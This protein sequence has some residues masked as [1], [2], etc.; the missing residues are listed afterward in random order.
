MHLW[1]ADMF[2]KTTLILTVLLLLKA[3]ALVAT[4]TPASSTSIQKM[5]AMP[6]AFTKNMGQWDERVLFRANAGGAIM[7]FTKEGVT[8]QFTRTISRSGDPM[9]RPGVGQNRFDFDFASLDSRLRGNDI[10]RDSVEQLVLTAKFLGANLNPEV[11]AEG[12]LEYK[13]NYFIGNDPTK[14]HTDV[15]NY[16][17][18]T[19]KDIYPGIDLRYSGDGG[20][21]AAYEFIAAPGA[22]IAQVKVE[23]EGAEGT[24]TD[25]EG[26]LTLTTKWG[27]MIAAMKSPTAGDLSGSVSCSQL[28]EKMIG[29]GAGGANRQALGILSF[30]LSYSTYLGGGGDDRG[31]GIAVDGF[32]CAYVTGYTESGDLP[33]LNAYDNTYG[34]GTDY[35]VAKL[36]A[37][38]NALVY[39]TYVGGSGWDWGRDIA[40]DGFGCAYVTGE[41]NSSDYPTQNAYD[42]SYNGGVVDVFVT[43]LSAAGSSLI[44]STYLGGSDNDSGHRLVVDGSGYVYVTGGTRS[45]GFPTQNPYQAYQGGWDVFVTKLSAAG[46]SLNYSTFLGGANA[47]DEQGDGIAVDGLGCAYVT[48]V[49]SDSKFPT[50]NAYDT[51]INGDEDAF[52][53]KFSAAGNAL[54]YSTY[55]GG[56]SGDGGNSIAVDGSGCAYM[57]GYTYSTNFPTQNPY[58]T[59][60]GS[61]DAFV[62][63]L[64][65]SGNI[66]V[67]STYLGGG[68]NEGGFKIAVDGSGNAFVTGVTWSSDFPTLNTYQTDQGDHDAF[69]TEFSSSGNSLIYST[70]LG[71]ANVDE[72]WDIA[73]DGSGNAYVTGLTYSSDFPI[74]NPCQST[75]QGG[76]DAFV[77][78]LGY[79]LCGNANGDDHV[80]IV[81]V[82]YLMAYIFNDSPAPDPLAAGNADGQCSVNIGD[83]VYLR[84]Y[85]FGEGPAPANCQPPSTCAFGTLA[86]NR[87]T[88]GCRPFPVDGDSVAIPIYVSNNIG[89]KGVSVGFHY[90]SDNIEVTSVDFAGSIAP[91]NWTRTALFKP[92]QNQVLVGAI[93]LGPSA[94]AILPQTGGLLCRLHARILAGDPSQPIDLDSSFVGPGGDFMIVVDTGNIRPEFVNCTADFVVVPTADTAD[95]FYVKQADIDNDNYSDVIYTGNTADSLY[96]AYGKADGTLETP[97]NYLKVTKAAL[98]VDFVNGDSL[99]DIVAHTTGKVYVL[100]NSGNRNFSIDSQNVSP[101]SWG[102]EADR[103]SAFPAIATGYFN[104][105]A[106]LDVVVSENKILYGNGNGSFPTSTTMSFSFDAV[107]V[108]DFDRNGTDDIAVTKGDSALIY[109]N[110]GNGNITRSAGV[111]IGY[112][113]HDF[114]S[115]GAG[116]D[117]NNDGKTDFVAVTG[118]TVGTNDTSV[119]TI[120]LGNG[121]GGVTS[122]DTLRI[123]GTALNLALADID[124]DHDLDISLVNATTRSLV[125]TANDG[126]GNFA[127]PVSTSLGSSSTEPLYA[128]INADLDRNGAPDFVIGGQ[129]GNPILSAINDL[130]GDPI[131]P[132]EMVTTGYNYVTLRVENPLGLVISR[133]L[134]TVA[135]SAYWRM[136]ADDNGVLDES[137]YDY[138]LQNGEYRVVIMCRANVAGNALCSVGI[139]IDGTAEC[140]MFRQYSVPALG[141]SIVFYYKVEP[142]SSIYPANGRPTAN[143]QPTFNWSNLVGKARMADSYEFQLDRYYDFLSPIFSVTGLT[144]PSYQIPHSLG[145]DSVFYWRIRPVTGG[146]PGNYSRTFAAYL[147]NY[148][149]GDANADA[150]VDISDAVYLIAYIF[151]GGS[152]PS[153]L[154]AGDANCDEAVDIAD[155]VYL[156]SYI[157]SGGAAPCA[158]CK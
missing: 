102:W 24:S 17:A 30:E 141:D 45:S 122:S 89:I 115:I 21:Q 149:C 107:A 99:L 55:L 112:R 78:K 81:D 18:I 10:E 144:S 27:D 93:R 62:T 103:S 44:Y 53:T 123:V 49:T 1:E 61:G 42:A 126:S 86:G 137:A 146:I 108:S 83:V 39:C 127:P 143:P 23:Y 34:G 92:A 87:I 101:T 72:G 54:V 40:V 19:I 124:K 52:V 148:L 70:Y 155:V 110:D 68:D 136:D 65:S 154:L 35:F 76:N 131:L 105:D 31:Y 97:R 37:A 71:G 117:L 8:Y 133:P 151:S 119:V 26:R 91:S 74:Q 125:I 139:R 142:V 100:L 80:D 114:A 129:S 152:A 6:L 75:F 20:G 15:P 57:T 16:E 118:N 135:G 73:I 56:A 66:L 43:K 128:L 98:A 22:D 95:V 48:G 46:N 85:I 138:N 158:G 90:P 5:N 77:T 130:P 59:D 25:A 113:A 64:G 51:G 2:Y 13:C 11:V 88:V 63:K 84:D 145:V 67:Y 60:Q 3:S 147:L 96:I 111:R 36:S 120:V 29:F 47:G 58:Q 140:S 9:G 132:D 153:P 82:T 12:Q 157:F 41:T 121:S 104:N 50:Q 79:F 28:S 7:W 32:G 69:V 14:W 109:V 150:S 33:V 38:G 106:H 94:S 4:A 134:S 156:I 116:I